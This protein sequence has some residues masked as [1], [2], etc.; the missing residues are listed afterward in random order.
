MKDLTVSTSPYAEYV[1]RSVQNVFS[2]KNDVQFRFLNKEPY[3]VN[4][5]SPLNITCLSDPYIYKNV[6]II[7][8][9]HLAFA[10]FTH[11]E[12]TYV[13]DKQ[14]ITTYYVKKAKLTMNGLFTCIGTLVRTGELRE[15]NLNA[16]VKGK[17]FYPFNSGQMVYR[18]L[19]M[20]SS[21]PKVFLKA[22]K[23]NPSCILASFLIL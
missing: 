6:S 4:E 10:L 23:T 22:F 8:P 20:S 16:T 15:I 14:R 3:I 7:A 12:N 2:D 21:I 11:S 13:E 5:K 19:K 1:D 17:I 9:T 18:L